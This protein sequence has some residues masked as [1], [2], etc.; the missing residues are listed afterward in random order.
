MIPIRILTPALFAATLVSCGSRRADIY[1]TPTSSYATTD[2]AATSVTD[3]ASTVYDAPAAYEDSAISPTASNTAPAAP[4]PSSAPEPGTTMTP[5]APSS[6]PYGAATIHTVVAGDTLSGIS[7]KYNIP[8]ASIR[9][10]NRMTNDVVILG[11]KMV[12]PP[13]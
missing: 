1:D 10:A 5:P 9:Q 2:Q 4:I 3:P 8:A 13:R 6:A 7:S 11:R 12:I